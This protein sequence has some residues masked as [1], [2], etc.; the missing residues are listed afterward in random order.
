MWKFK[1]KSSIHVSLGCSANLMMNG[2]EKKIR[3]EKKF[4]LQHYRSSFFFEITLRNINVLSVTMTRSRGRER[5][6]KLQF[7]HILC[8]YLISN[9]VSIG[10][11]ARHGSVRVKRPSHTLSDIRHSIVIIIRANRQNCTRT[12]TILITRTE[13][14]FFLVS[15]QHCCVSVTKNS[16][17]R[18]RV[19]E[20]LHISYPSRVRKF[21]NVYG[22]LEAFSTLFHFI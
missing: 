22:K 19:T 7:N 20:L 10:N 12:M 17:A 16:R 4:R 5:A 6:W 9:F 1:K 11:K 21:W 14:L 18:S 2:W 15:T 8:L 3:R 13:K